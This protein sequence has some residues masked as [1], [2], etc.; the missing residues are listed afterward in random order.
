MKYLITGGAGFIGTNLCRKLL[1]DNNAVLCLDDLSTGK[2]RNIEDL[3]KNPNFE[4]FK[5]DLTKPF[6]PDKVDAIFNLACP[7]SPVHYQYNPIRTLKMGTL[8]MYNVLGMAARLNIPILQASTSEIYGD[9]SVHPQT[10]SYLGNVNPIGPRACYD[11]GKRVAE[12]LCIAYQNYNNVDIRIARIF[13]TYG[14]YM[15]PKD[16]RVV[17]NFINQALANEPIT[18]YGQG[19]QT[20]SFCYVS[21][22]VEG[23]I[24][25]MKSRYS[26]PVN[27]GNPEEYDILQFAQLIK[28]KIGSSSKIIFNELPVDDPKQ[29]CPDISLAKETLEWA[30]QVSLDEGLQNT[31]R[32]YQK[33]SDLDSKK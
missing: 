25:L 27:L 32:W 17:S 8:A 22:L 29:R 10:E 24:K 31:I 9:P 18:V 20:R 5:H 15:D 7:A 21:D 28:E 13:N 33:I 14:P 11:E 1:E 16:G 2:Y 3:V 26:L 23:L 6:F 4:F 30:P 12:A 19:S